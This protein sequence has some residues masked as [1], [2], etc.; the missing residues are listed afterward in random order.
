[1]LTIVNI[2][3]QAKANV[4]DWRVLGSGHIRSKQQYLCPLQAATGATMDYIAHALTL[5]RVSEH[6]LITFV[7]AADSVNPSSPIGRSFRALMVEILKPED[8]G[9]F[10]ELC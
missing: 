8:G 7:A 3:K 9:D 5:W 10:V 2:L 6:R 1:M 4:P